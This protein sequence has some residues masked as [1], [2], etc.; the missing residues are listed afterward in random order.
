M[1]AGA[2]MSCP[3]RGSEEMS[4]TRALPGRSA[5]AAPT[6]LQGQQPLEERPVPAKDDS[7]IFRGSVPGFPELTL[8][9]LALLGKRLREARHDLRYE[10][11]SFLNGL[12]RVV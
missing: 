4:A 1:S 7:Q 5:V 11:I 8:Q 6:G 3:L 12:A 10:L 2:A 9:V